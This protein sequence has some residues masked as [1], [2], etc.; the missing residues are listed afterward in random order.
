MNETAILM[1]AGMGTRMRPLTETVPKPLVRV[2]GVPMIETVIGGLAERGVKRYIVVTGYLGGQFG[3]LEEK[4]DG[5]EIIV[6]RD[7]ETINNIS[8]LYH[9]ADEL[10]G[11]EGGCFICEA[12]L[13]VSD[14]RLFDCELTHSCYFGK[15]VSG[16]SDDWVFDTDENGRITRVGKAGDDRYNMVGISWFMRDDA[17]LLGQLI[18]DAYGSEGYE[19]L[20]WDDVVNRNLDRLDLTVHEISGGSIAEIDTVKELAEIDPSYRQFISA[21]MK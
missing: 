17:R 3:Y 5:L 11:A 9:A 21:Q 1:A 19:E 20:F 14:T 16:H 4:Y 6:N 12:D 13:Y 15:M 2:N 7:Y 18:K 10:I 8:S